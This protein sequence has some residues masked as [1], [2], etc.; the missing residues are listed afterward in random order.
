MIERLQQIASPL[1]R[2]RPLIVTLGLASL[3]VFCLSLF[4]AAGIDADSYMMPAVAAVAWSGL[5]LCVSYLFQQVPAK[6]N[7]GQSLFTRAGLH[8]RRSLYW[9]L[10]LAVLA[11]TTTVL[12]LSWQM[13]RLTLF[14]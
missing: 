14:G 4:G 10:A 6:P 5:L 2:L 1:A 7:P 12:I 9:I 8:L 13:L 3:L 11:L